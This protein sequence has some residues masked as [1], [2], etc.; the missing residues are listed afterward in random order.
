MTQS[1]SA[2]VRLVRDDTGVPCGSLQAIEV[3]YQQL[4]R[5]GL[6][7]SQIRKAIDNMHPRLMENLKLNRKGMVE[8]KDQSLMW[9]GS[10]EWIPKDRPLRG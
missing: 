6:T 8:P 2:R 10:C 5:N 9:I 1:R 3:Q 7:K 4:S